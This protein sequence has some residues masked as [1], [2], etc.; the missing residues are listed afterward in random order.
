MLETGWRIVDATPAEL[1]ALHAHG[2]VTQASVM[3][4]PCFVHGTQPHHM[5]GSDTRPLRLVMQLNDAVLKASYTDQAQRH[6]AMPRCKEGDAFPDKGGHDGD[7]EFVN[8]VL[9][10]EGPDDFPPPSSSRSCQRACGG[11]RR[12]PRSTR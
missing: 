10:Q 7:D 11:V 3:A 9:V 5:A 12:R 1:A 8:R 2:L 6:L 4:R